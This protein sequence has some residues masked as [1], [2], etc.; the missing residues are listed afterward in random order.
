MTNMCNVTKDPY[1]YYIKSVCK[2][3]RKISESYR[4]MDDTLK[5]YK[6]RLQNN[7]YKS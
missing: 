2:S 1:F 5:I 6:S 7:Q 4:N 3:I